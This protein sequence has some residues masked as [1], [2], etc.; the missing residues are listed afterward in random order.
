M[1]YIE[2]LISCGFSDEDA[3]FIYNEYLADNDPVGLEV[4]TQAAEIEAEW[5]REYVAGI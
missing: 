3:W 4:F 5:R 2:R 1:D